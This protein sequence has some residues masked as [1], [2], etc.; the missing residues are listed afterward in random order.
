MIRPNIKVN[1]LT[2]I[3]TEKESLYFKVENIYKEDGINLKSKVMPK[4]YTQMVIYT[5]DKLF[6]WKNMAMVAYIFRIIQN[7]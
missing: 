3:F 4:S 6:S 2:K 5:T 1:F 7:I